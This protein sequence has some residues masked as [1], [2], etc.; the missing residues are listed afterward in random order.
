M[1]DGVLLKLRILLK[2]RNQKLCTRMGAKMKTKRRRKKKKHPQQRRVH[3]D[4]RE[5]LMGNSLKLFIRT[6]VLM[7]KKKMKKLPRQRKCQKEKMTV[8]LKLFIKMI[9]IATMKRMRRKVTM[10]VERT[11]IRLRQK[12]HLKKYQ[13][14]SLRGKK[15]K[16]LQRDVGDPRRTAQHPPRSLQLKRKRVNIHTLRIMRCPHQKASWM[17]EL[18]LMTVATETGNLMVLVVSRRRRWFIESMKVKIQTRDG[19]LIK[20][21][22][23]LLNPSK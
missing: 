21:R 11:I 15:A 5:I 14:K 17:P 18:F 9:W 1:G 19:S 13:Q 4:P 20:Q 8:N 12:Q 3:G 2:V 23:N 7:K 6:K 22:K 16:L 10:T